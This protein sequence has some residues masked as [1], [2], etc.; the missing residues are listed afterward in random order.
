MSTGKGD[1]AHDA[2]AWKLSGA[3]AGDDGA[4]EF[5]AGAADESID[6][7]GVDR[8]TLLKVMG[9]GLAAWSMGSMTGC[10]KPQPLEKIVPYVNQPEGLVPG[11]PLFYA[12]AIPIDGW[13]RGVVV[14]Q[15]EGRPTKIE[16]NPDHPSS[17]GAT[18]L[19]TQ[20]AILQLYD[21]DRTKTVRRL[22]GGG[23]ADTWSNF[24]ESLRDFIAQKGGAATLRVRVLTGT[25][26]SPTIA[27]QMRRLTQLFPHW[28]WHR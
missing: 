25:I 23:A 24:Q 8:R 15:H 27:A 13:A 10:F 16:G 28:G 4:F 7:R 17:L 21:P 22:T 9:A 5:A 3:P 20:A 14:E 26:T 6:G 11:I 12:S 2:E 19:F 18:D 1:C